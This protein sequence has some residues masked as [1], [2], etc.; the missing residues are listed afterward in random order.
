MKTTYRD[1]NVVVAVE[2]YSTKSGM[3][4]TAEI[5]D[6]LNPEAVF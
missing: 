4:D 2:E 1:N 3:L 6:S 5:Y